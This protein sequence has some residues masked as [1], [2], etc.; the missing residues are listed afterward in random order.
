MEEFR[1]ALALDPTFVPARVNLAYALLLTGRC[2]EAAAEF[3][4][5]V[6]LGRQEPE[7]ILVR[8]FAA[9]VHGGD[10]DAMR[11]MRELEKL[12][13]RRGVY[14]F[15]AALLYALIGQRDAAFRWLERG[16]AERSPDMVYLKTHPIADQLRGDPR[17][18]ALLARIGLSPEAKPAI[19]TFLHP[20]NRSSTRDR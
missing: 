17:L 18:D 20:V 4:A 6:A 5:A 9:T 2:D 3:G 8:A 7:A 12:K 19:S 16:Y 15:R 14:P 13:R 11:I 1:G 10:Q